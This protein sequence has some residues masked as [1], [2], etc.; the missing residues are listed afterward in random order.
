MSKGI[1][2]PFVNYTTG[3]GGDTGLDDPTAIRPILNGEDVVGADPQVGSGGVVNRPGEHLRRRT[4]KLRD[5]LE[6]V[7]YLQGADRA[8]LLAGPGRV[9][10]PGP[11]TTG[12]SGVLTLDGPL[13][14]VPAL[15]PGAAQALPIPP[16]A[17]MFGRLVLEKADGNPGLLVSSLRRSYE[18]GDRISLAVVPGTSL[19]VEAQGVP[20]RSILLTAPPLA[21]LAQVA[22]LLG[23]LNADDPPRPLVSVA[24][25]PGALSN[26]LLLV[27][28]ARQFVEGNCDGEGHTLMP[29]NLATFFTS[30]PESALAEGDTLCIQYA[31][32]T[33]ET[34][35][36]GGRR[37]STPENSNTAIPAGSFFNSRVSPEKLTNAIPVCK[38]VGGRLV[39]MSGAHVPP[40]AAGF[41]LGGAA[42]AAISYAGGPP[43]RDGTTNPAT[44]VEA[45]LDK[46]IADLTSE[47]VAASGG[48][49]IA[50]DA[51]T[52][53]FGARAAESL[54]AR[55]DAI[56]AAKPNLHT[57]NTLTKPLTINTGNNDNLGS[58]L[59]STVAPTSAYKPILF[60]EGVNG[61]HV[62]IYQKRESNGIVITSNAHWDPDN[63]AWRHDSD[64]LAASYLSI[65]QDAFSI[66]TR[67]EGVAAWADDAW[68]QI[69]LSHDLTSGVLAVLGNLQAGAVATAEAD[70]RHGDRTKSILPCR[71]EDG[72]HHQG[73]SVSAGTTI[74]AVF[75]DVD[76]A[77]GDRVKLVR[78]I[79]NVVGAVVVDPQLHAAWYKET[80]V[81]GPT[82]PSLANITPFTGM[83]S[84]GPTE[85]MELALV[86]PA[87]VVL[88]AGERHVIHI[89]PAALTNTTKTIYRVEVVYDRPQ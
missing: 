36:L 64:F 40:G 42:G 83:P 7:L 65:D 4:E 28:Q 67:A 51:T 27:P 37:Q 87:P 73:T 72:W 78:V 1:V 32:M 56:A 22:G 17:S 12:Q 52:Y 24:L 61:G 10:W 48:D 6:D 44:T 16:V 50:V 82:G 79:Y 26:D 5:V 38:V 20:A 62:W 29:S 80:A 86:P 76:L 41:D 66:R 30:N 45:Q 25:A 71:I 43:W 47:A 75:W 68:T 9:T 2:Q 69:A 77:V 31:K 8:L 35:S 39:F 11:T 23:A 60:L 74:G 15:T 3:T 88:G 70:V 89:V 33:D 54:K 49:K 34:G 13:F 63:N 53:S 19:A 84:G 58:M 57:V 18:G 14:V 81:A 85:V 21:T 55:I 46:I 59:Q